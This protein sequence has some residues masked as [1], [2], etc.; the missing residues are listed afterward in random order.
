MGEE[1]DWVCEFPLSDGSPCG[2]PGRGAKTKCEFHAHVNTENTYVGGTPVV[3]QYVTQSNREVIDFAGIIFEGHHFDTTQLPDNS[4]VLFDKARFDGC[5]FDGCILRNASFV[6]ADFLNNSKFVDCGF[7]GNSCTFRNSSFSSDRAV[8]DNCQFEFTQNDEAGSGVVRFDDCRADVGPE[9]F[10]S[11]Y[12][13]AP[14]FSIRHLELTAKTGYPSL[15]MIVTDSGMAASY[16]MLYLD[17]VKQISMTGLNMR[18]GT[19][20]YR[21]E[22]CD[23]GYEPLLL[24]DE[25]DFDQMGSAKLFNAT[26]TNAHLKNSSLERVKFHSCRWL[27]QEGFR[28]IKADMFS[29]KDYLH[30]KDQIRLY[31]QLKKN[32][33]SERNFIEA[34]DWFYREMETRR[35]EALSTG[36]EGI[37]FLKTLIAPISLYKWASKYGESYWKPFGWLLVVWSFF[38]GLYFYSG[39]AIGSDKINYNWEWMALSGQNVQDFLQAMLCSLGVMSFQAGRSIELSSSWSVFCSIV[40]LILTTILVPLFLLA[41]RR[42]FRR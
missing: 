14:E 23:K 30:Y 21:Q 6:K 42:K 3:K 2:L 40:Q 36:S 13:F 11:T 27:E 17:R 5:T 37:R 39:F 7:V 25:I 10:R 1:T 28:A 38:S 24:L 18:D 4:Q 32:F 19:F 26:L 41:V 35:A 22:R 29:G 31:V 20:V 16:R 33:E 8:F 15:H 12:V 34:G 9:L